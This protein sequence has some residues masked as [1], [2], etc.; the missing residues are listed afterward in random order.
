MLKNINSF[1]GETKSDEEK[2]LGGWHKKIF[3]NMKI[4]EELDKQTN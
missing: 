2:N 3:L 1:F 4:F